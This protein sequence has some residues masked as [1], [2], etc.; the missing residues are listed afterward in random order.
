MRDAEELTG[1]QVQRVLGILPPGR[2]GQLQLH[3]AAAGE[4]Q[5]GELGQ[6]R[7]ALYRTVERAGQRQA[8]GGGLQR[9][10]ELQGAAE[11][12]RNRIEQEAAGVLRR[13]VRRHLHRA[14]ER[15]R[16]VERELA[17][18]RLGEAVEIELAAERPDL[19]AGD[20]EIPAAE[21]NGG[22]VA[23]FFVARQRALERQSAG[24]LGAE[25]AGEG[26]EIGGGQPVG[27]VDVAVLQRPVEI[28]TEVLGL[29]RS[30]AELQRAVVGEL[31][32]A[33]E[34]DAGA[35]QLGRLR[36]QRAAALQM[37]RQGGGAGARQI[38]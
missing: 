30:G 32:A 23:G 20:D 14:V 24:S 12:D 36:R 27:E 21:V 4:L 22:A 19:L 29:H 11:V 33:G 1:L 10:G 37:P 16:G 38:V 8:A 2:G 34:V 13:H 3:R 28:D 31:D 15:G 18:R 9:A 25:G 6:Q 5:A 17:A 35:Q 7:A 26:G